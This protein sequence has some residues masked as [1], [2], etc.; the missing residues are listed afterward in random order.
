MDKNTSI[1]PQLQENETL[2]VVER[3][4]KAVQAMKEQ[5]DR[6]EAITR[7]QEEAA[8]K[9]M[10]GGQTQAG[11]SQPQKTEE[12][13]KKEGAIEFFKGTGI[14]KAIKRYE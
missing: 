4:E 13:L 5:N 14:D 6:A 7:R 10:L 11:Q 12:Q 9:A 8:A 1:E 3:A 2:N